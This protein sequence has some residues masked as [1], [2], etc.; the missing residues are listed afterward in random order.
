MA[1]TPE[2][3][4]D[5]EARRLISQNIER[6]QSLKEKAIKVAAQIEESQNRLDELV[7]KARERYNTGDVEELKRIREENE[8]KN[9]ERVLAWLRQIER[10]ETELKALSGSASAPGR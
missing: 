9:A 5:E 1:N 8:F 3:M 10:V 7:A 6:H 4:S 2:R